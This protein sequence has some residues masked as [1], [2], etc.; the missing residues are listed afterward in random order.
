MPRPPPIP[1][2]ERVRFRLAQSAGAQV[3]RLLPRGYQRLGDLLVVR[4][5]E[6]LAPHAREV[7]EAYREEFRVRNV[8]ASDGGEEGEFRHPRLRPLLPGESTETL[9]REAGLLWELDVA[10]VMFSKGNRHERE[11]MAWRVRP[12]ERVCDLF[13]GIG[14]FTLPMALRGTHSTFWAVEKNPVAFDYLQRN[15]LRNG[16]SP[17]VRALLGDN[18]EVEL[19]RASFDRVVM[20]YLPSSLPFLPRAVGLLD[21]D[22]GWVHA[23]LLVGSRDPV[24]EAQEAFHRIAHHEG[25]EVLESAWHPVKAYG[26]GRL[27]GVVDARL[28][29]PSRGPGQALGATTLGRSAFNAAGNASRKASRSE[30]RLEKEARMKRDP[31]LGDR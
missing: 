12:G 30:G 18:R 11:R 8:L 3:A 20:G 23:H 9:H 31:N 1:P 27:H 5:P 16:L 28:R 26:P 22:G 17:R 14:Y 24:G 7:A 13:A 21:P 2:V 10:Q 6:A 29:P 4:L 25:A 15:L 19:P